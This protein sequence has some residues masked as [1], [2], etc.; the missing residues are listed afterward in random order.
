MAATVFAAIAAVLAAISLAVCA[1]LLKRSGRGSGADTARL[2]QKIDRANYLS[3][4]SAQTA[5]D[6]L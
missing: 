2:E 4:N 5:H 1:L 6:Y 3:E